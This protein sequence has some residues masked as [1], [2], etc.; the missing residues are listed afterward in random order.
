MQKL[1]LIIVCALIYSINFYSLSNAKSIRLIRDTEIEYFLQKLINEILIV[2][3]VEIN[4]IKPRLLLN[5]DI[6][7]FII[8][9][10]KIYVNTGLLENVTSVDEI[11]GILAHEIGHLLLGHYQSRKVFIR[12]NTQNLSLAL[13]TMLGASIAKSNPNLNGFIL[14]TKDLDKKL[15]SKYSKQQEM[16][17]DIFA[18]NSLKKLNL[19]LKGLINFFEKTDKK[20]KILADHNFHTYYASHPSPEKRLK[21]IRSLSRKSNT[22]LRQ[23]I[24]FKFFN[25]PLKQIQIKIHVISNNKNKLE[26]FDTENDPFLNEYLDLAKSYLNK[27]YDKALINAKTILLIDKFNP[28]LFEVNGNLN[29]QLNKLDQAIFNYSKALKLAQNSNIKNKSLIKLSLA[30]AY[31]KKNNEINFKKSFKLLEE[32][33]P[34]EKSNSL[35]WRNIAISSGKLKKQSIAYIAL[36]EEQVIKNNLKKAKK[37]AL[38]GLKDKNLRYLYKIR[39]KDILNLK[40]LEK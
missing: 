2:K 1:I 39:G 8:G 27:N 38:L 4:S 33:M 17:A 18:I 7:A 3:N 31:I 36:A 12:K 6:N 15:K 32:I 22:S 35:L 13:F 9:N 10:E 19:S 37:Y 21:L 29:L 16:E 28:F 23:K 24:N 11:Q 26:E 5:N 34:Y 30:R 25:I 20:Y 14:A 40:P